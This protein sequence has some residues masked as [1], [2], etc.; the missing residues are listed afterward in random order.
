[1]DISC[2]IVGRRLFILS[3]YLGFTSNIFIRSMQL[4]IIN[5]DVDRLRTFF[6]SHSL[7]DTHTRGQSVRGIPGVMDILSE[8]KGQKL[9]A[10]HVP[11]GYGPGPAPGRGVAYRTRV[12][13]DQGPRQAAAGR[14]G[15]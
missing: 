12:L 11:S 3:I 5:H 13:T 4:H 10:R 7:Y 8:E 1:M 2:C 15:P 14:T 9:M 6:A